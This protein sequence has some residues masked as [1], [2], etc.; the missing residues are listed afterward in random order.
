MPE[1]TGF[2]TC[3][4]WR[5]HGAQNN[6][7]NTARNGVNK[8]I[9]TRAAVKCIASRI[10]IE[11]IVVGCSND[12]FNGGERIGAARFGDC[13]GGVKIDR[14]SGKACISNAVY[15]SRGRAAIEGIVACGGRRKLSE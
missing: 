11:R 9:H 3:R 12:R 15:N 7:F 2:G 8:G 4:G 6:G 10:G 1:N 14:N 5:L 13:Q